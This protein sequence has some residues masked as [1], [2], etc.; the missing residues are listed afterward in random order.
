M[1]PARGRSGETAVGGLQEIEDS[2]RLELV[3]VSFQALLVEGLPLS[4][5]LVI[6]TEIP[7]LQGDAGVA[8]VDLYGEV[9]LDPLHRSGYYSLD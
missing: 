8:L 2:I 1:N 6:L 7:L 3:G 9:G 5:A 4:L